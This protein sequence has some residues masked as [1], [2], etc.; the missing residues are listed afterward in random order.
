MIILVWFLSVLIIGVLIGEIRFCQLKNSQNA[1]K[2]FSIG[3][4]TDSIDRDMDDID[5]ECSQIEFVPTT[6]LAMRG[7]WR[8]GQDMSLD[9]SEFEELR[10]SEYSKS[11]R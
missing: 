9:E 10:E 8:L 2:E 11:L 5:V 3:N 1:D 4:W 6:K 7:S